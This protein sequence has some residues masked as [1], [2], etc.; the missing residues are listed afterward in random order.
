MIKAHFGKAPSFAKVF[1]FGVYGVALAGVSCGGFCGEKRSLC[2]LLIVNCLKNASEW[3]WY[4]LE[5]IL[6]LIFD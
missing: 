6:Y 1:L 5:K 4:D 3:S 2:N